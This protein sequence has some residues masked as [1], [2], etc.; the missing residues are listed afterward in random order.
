VNVPGFI[1]AQILGGVA[2]AALLKWLLSVPAEQ[3]TRKN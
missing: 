1:V 3:V 2:A